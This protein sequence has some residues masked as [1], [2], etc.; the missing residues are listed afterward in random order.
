[1]T[2]RPRPYAAK[3]VGMTKSESSADLH[4]YRTGE[5]LRRATADELSASVAA[6]DEDGG[7]GVIDVE[8]V[9]CYDVGTTN[10]APTSG[11]I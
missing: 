7:A 6:A 10:D 2:T 8:G 9:Y 3:V 1:M 5:F 11:A 4:D